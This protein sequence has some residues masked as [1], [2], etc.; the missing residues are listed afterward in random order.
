MPLGDKMKKELVGLI[1]A[2]FLSLLLIRPVSAHCPLCTAATGFAV[3]AARWYGVDDLIVGTFIGGLVVSSTLWMNNI[4][5][6]KKWVLL[7]H[8]GTILVILTILSTI[9]T[10]YFAGLL[11]NTNPSF[12]IFGVD[13]LFVATMLGSAITMV[14]FWFHGIMRK[15]NGGRNFIPFQGIV[16]LFVFLIAT[17]GTFYL[18]G[19]I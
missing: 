19:V 18:A 10:Y 5:I 6:K 3:M 2:S 11:N 15:M 16:L 8:Q 4:L 1:F 9:L 17:S 7:P 13:K 12:R 14:S